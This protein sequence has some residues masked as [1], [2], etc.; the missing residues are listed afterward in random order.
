MQVESGL[1]HVNGA[2]AATVIRVEESADTAAV[3]AESGQEEAMTPL[4]GLQGDEADSKT[5]SQSLAREE[6]MQRVQVMLQV[7]QAPY[8]RRIMRL[9]Y[10]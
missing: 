7:I 2:L 4:G 9:Q 3:R 5:N 8:E 1:L 10:F 6:S